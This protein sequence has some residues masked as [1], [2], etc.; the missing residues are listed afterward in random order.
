MEKNL[1]HEVGR[2]IDDSGVLL[3]VCVRLH[4]PHQLHD[5]L[6]LC[7]I[8]VA[9]RLELQAVRQQHAPICCSISHPSFGA[10]T[11][12]AIRQR[13]RVSERHT[14]ATTLRP[15]RRADSYACSIDFSD[16]T[17]PVCT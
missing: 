2:A 15:E 9:C 4:V 17:L 5:S 12:A 11:S 14:W 3:K 10:E 1:S 8:S 16:G 13:F 7:E 6:D